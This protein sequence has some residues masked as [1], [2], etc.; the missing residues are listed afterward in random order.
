VNPVTILTFV[1]N[2]RLFEE[3]YRRFITNRLKSMLPI[4]EAPIRLLVRS[5]RDR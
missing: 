2:P 3:N 1:N 4:D 5:R